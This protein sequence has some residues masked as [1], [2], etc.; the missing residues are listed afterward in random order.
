MNT[1]SNVIQFF[2]PNMEK[3]CLWNDRIN[4]QITQLN[5]VLVAH[6]RPVEINR[7]FIVNMNFSAGDSININIYIAILKLATFKRLFI[8]KPI[9]WPSN[10]LICK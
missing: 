9:R 7:F 1:I 8:P 4:C 6:E 2:N 10:R 5:T 3:P